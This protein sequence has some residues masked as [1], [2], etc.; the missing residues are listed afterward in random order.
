MFHP[1]GILLQVP[2]LSFPLLI[3]L[4]A[5]FKSTSR[6]LSFPLPF[7]KSSSS[8]VFPKTWCDRRRGRNGFCSIGFHAAKSAKILTLEI[9]AQHCGWK[10][11]RMGQAGDKMSEERVLLEF[12]SE[13]VVGNTC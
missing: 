5:L 12:S 8:P 6:I 10:L 3:F 13:S 1:F 7:R 2:T 11:C 9:L 4:S